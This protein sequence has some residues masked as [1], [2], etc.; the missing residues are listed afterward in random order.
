MNKKRI[1]NVL[2]IVLIIISIFN[3]LSAN[4]IA[5]DDYSVE[6]IL[7]IG[8]KLNNQYMDSGNEVQS[9]SAFQKYIDSGIFDNGT[10]A[11]SASCNSSKITGTNTVETCII[12][13]PNEC[14]EAQE[15]YDKNKTYSSYAASGLKQHDKSSGK[16]AAAMEGF[17]KNAH[18][19]YSFLMGFGC[20]TSLLVFII[21]FVRITWLPEHA[22]QRREAMEDI[23][24]SGVSVMLLGGFW[25]IVGV[26]QSMFNRFWESYTVFTKDWQTAAN[27]FLVEYRSLIV[28][29]L[30]VATLTALL[31]FIKSITSVVIG[32]ASSPQ[33]KTAKMTQ[34][35][36]CGLATAGLGG[37]TIF[38]GL[39]WNMLR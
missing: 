17:N 15:Y 5:A 28:G 26:F 38:A 12:Q 8:D 18:Y 7:G 2:I 39:F 11:C 21:I 1:S 37:L 24:T 16:L 36:Y 31:M 29:I 19:V 20:L 9:S 22:T 3:I 35:L 13:H 34:V 23:V 6:G 4:V 25:L 10:G 32:S 33:Q 27:V 14:S 30:G